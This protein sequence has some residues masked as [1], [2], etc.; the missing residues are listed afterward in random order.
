MNS[1]DFSIENP[2]W[3]NMGIV[4]N[5]DANKA[6]RGKIYNVFKEGVNNV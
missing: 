1:I 6:T 5:K 2:M 3:R 4:G